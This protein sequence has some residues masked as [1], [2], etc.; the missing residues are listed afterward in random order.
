M[1]D[2]LL[3]ETA[4]KVFADTCSFDAVE[5]AEAAGWAAG[6]WTALADTGLAWVGVPE[7]AGGSGGT[8]DDALEV[9][10]IAGAH[11]APVPLAETGV[12]GGWLL[13]GAGLTVP[14]GPATVAPGN[15]GDD[16]ALAG[17]RVTGVVHR[18]PWAR[19]A[20]RIVLLGGTS[21]PTL[22]S[23]PADSVRV[24]PATN[25]AGEPRDTVHFDGVAAEVAPAGPGVDA[26]TVR[27]R[28]ALTRVALMAGALERMVD[29]AVEY[30]A[31]RHQ[32]GKAIATFQA[33]QAHLVHAAQDAA[34]VNMA[35]AQAGRAAVDGDG[36]FEIASAKILAN[37]AA[38][39]ATRHVHQAHGAMGLTR[40][41]PLH[42]SSRRLWAW[43]SEYGDEREWMRVLGRTV[44][45]EGAD[46]LYP[47]I[48]G[49]S[50]VLTN[51]A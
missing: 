49:G 4:R 10:R 23:I 14:S 28:G 8:L 19:T 51:P 24:E 36:W 6:V 2:A 1:A 34:L 7:A 35:L 3:T 29:L 16:V 17:S 26:A 42:H 31:Q 30:T 47:V 27:A 43:R 32:F 39:T 44:I 9:L 21:A 20:E 48:T 22:I 5:E 40:E 15:P 38:S 18:V 25:L 13:A 45:G 33:V 11:S 41:Y 46:R 50:G 12:L 37:Q